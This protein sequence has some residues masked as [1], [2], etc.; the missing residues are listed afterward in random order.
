MAIATCSWLFVAWA[1]TCGGAHDRFD[2][3]DNDLGFHTHYVRLLR[4]LLVLDDPGTACVRPQRDAFGYFPSTPRSPGSARAQLLDLTQT[5]A[6]G[7][8]R[9]AVP[10]RPQAT[11]PDVGV[12]R[13]PALGVAAAP[14]RAGNAVGDL[15][16]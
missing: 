4:A 15:A 13:D 14:G 12:G 16:P 2:T 6:I 3:F 11:R 9:A 10:H 7:L 1:S 8:R 5:L